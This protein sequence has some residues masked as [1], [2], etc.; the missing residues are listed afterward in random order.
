MHLS[1][2]NPAGI[3]DLK[4]RLARDFFVPFSDKITKE[5]VDK[6]ES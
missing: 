3:D 1:Q 6:S 4:S 5:D 2:T